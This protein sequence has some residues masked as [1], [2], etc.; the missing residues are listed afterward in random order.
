MM[1]PDMYE[2]EEKKERTNGKKVSE[3]DGRRRIVLG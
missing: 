1:A 2:S 3:D